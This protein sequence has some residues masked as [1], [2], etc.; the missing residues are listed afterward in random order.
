MRRRGF[1]V[2]VQDLDHD[3]KLFR[4]KDEFERRVKRINWYGNEYEALGFRSAILYRNQ[5]WYESLKFEYDMSVPNVA[6]LDPQRGGCCTVMPYFV[7]N[8]LELPVTT[9]QDHT[10]FHILNDFSIDLWRQQSELILEQNGLVSFIVH[11]DYIGKKRAQ[12]TYRSLLAFL[13]ELR[14]ERNVWVALPG[15]V[16]QWWRQRDQM[17]IIYNNGRC[18]IEGSGS[19]RARLAFASVEND[20]LIYRLADEPTGG[21]NFLSRSIVGRDSFSVPRD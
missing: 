18:L 13:T 3:G 7:G 21:S 4:D 6:H 8:L 14:S 11:P 19:E 5:G 9:T 10:L 16:N 15:E 2:N 20:R 12:D 17:N 1:E